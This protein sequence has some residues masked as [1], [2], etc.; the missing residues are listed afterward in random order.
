MRDLVRTIACITAMILLAQC[1]KDP[2]PPVG[3]GDESFL[4]ALI[5]RGVDTNGDGRISREEAGALTYLDVAYCGISDMSGIEAF[6][7]LDTLFCDWNLITDL[8][9]SG[10]TALIAFG[11]V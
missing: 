1:E 4:N 10:N 6:V 3:I 2:D 11:P 8:D 7:N 9:V 5:E